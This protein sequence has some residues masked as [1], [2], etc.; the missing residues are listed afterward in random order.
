MYWHRQGQRVIRF[1]PWLFGKYFDDNLRNTVPHEVAHYLCDCLYGMRT[2]RPHGKE[3]RALMRLLDAEPQVRH[4]YDLQGVPQ[5]R[6]HRFA[7]RCG[8][9]RHALSAQ[10]HRRIQRGLGF[11]QCRH[12]GERLLPDKNPPSP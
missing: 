8:C 2:I 6:Q 3:W 4:Q 1:N 7:Y 10:R 5:R 9:R 11:Y 12:C